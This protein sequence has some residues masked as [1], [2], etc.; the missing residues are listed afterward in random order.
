MGEFIIK[1]LTT[2]FE[3]EEYVVD[4]I[5]DYQYQCGRVCPMVTLSLE[6]YALEPYTDINGN[7]ITRICEAG[8]SIIINDKE[9]LQWIEHFKDEFKEFLLEKYPEE[10]LK[11]QK[12]FNDYCGDI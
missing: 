9:S 10:F 1:S 7:Y 6:L 12:F 2:N 11:N 8:K 4:T 5:N 3:N